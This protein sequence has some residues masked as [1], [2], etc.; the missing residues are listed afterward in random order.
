MAHPDPE[1]IN[2]FVKHAAEGITAVII[3]ALALLRYIGYKR[4]KVEVAEAVLKE[5]P[6]SHSELLQC[7]ITVT[8]TLNESMRLQLSEFRQ[9]F[10]TEIRSLHEKIHATRYLNSKDK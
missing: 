2:F 6:V 8:Q 3:G 4:D 10:M 5:R 9:E 1:H 7:Q